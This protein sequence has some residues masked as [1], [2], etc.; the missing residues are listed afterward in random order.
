MDQCLVEALSVHVYCRSGVM[1]AVQECDVSGGG[2][3]AHSG[4]L[5][6]CLYP[7]WDVF[8][9]RFEGVC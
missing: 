3:G 6:P 5:A 7:Q 4:E 2:W 9:E 1:Y 8:F